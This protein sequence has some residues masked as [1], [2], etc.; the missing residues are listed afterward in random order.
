M[1][2]LPRK[3]HRLHT[4]LTGWLIVLA[5]FFG[6]ISDN[7]AAMVLEHTHAEGHHRHEHYAEFQQ[8]PCSSDCG[9]DETPDDHDQSPTGGDAHHHQMES[10]HVH[11]G[12]LTEVAGQPIC[13]SFTRLSW[14]ST[15]ESVP[16]G[17]SFELIKPPQIG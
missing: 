14:V 5:A 3:K 10:A 8:I 16:D 11:L 4:I 9:R 12:Y 2:M 13:L 1:S 15:S 7:R 17:P 6:M